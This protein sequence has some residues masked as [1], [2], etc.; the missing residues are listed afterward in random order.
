MDL[1]NKK[2]EAYEFGYYAEEMAAQEYLK[3]GYTVLERQWKIGKTEIDIILQ[4][5]NVIVLVE[6]KARN[7]SE[8]D[9]LSAVTRD[10]RKRMIRAA[11]SY[12]NSLR[13]NFDYRFDIVACY[14][15]KKN[16]QIK[17]FENAFVSTDIF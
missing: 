9:A 3:R 7:T 13:G 8:E 1:K 16:F 15:N 5:N 10:K 12:L 11:D 14:G 2:L 6:V 4:K 17:I